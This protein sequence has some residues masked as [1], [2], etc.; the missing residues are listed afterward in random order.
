MLQLKIILQES[1]LQHIYR[2]YSSFSQTLKK[3][4][5]IMEN[6][7]IKKPTLGEIPDLS[8]NLT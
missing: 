4:L 6:D 3:L 5:K 2:F 8:R 1:G 7:I